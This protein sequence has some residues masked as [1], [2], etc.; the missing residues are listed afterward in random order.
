M[1]RLTVLIG[2]LILFFVVMFLNWE[3]YKL[4]KQYSELQK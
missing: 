3:L 1:N 2:V 4:N